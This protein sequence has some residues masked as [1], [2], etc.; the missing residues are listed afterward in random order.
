MRRHKKSLIIDF[1]LKVQALGLA[2]INE[3]FL[4]DLLFDKTKEFKSYYGYF[5]KGHIE[6]MK[7]YGDP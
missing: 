4:K 5:N 3:I 6:M 2:T 7:P 1:L